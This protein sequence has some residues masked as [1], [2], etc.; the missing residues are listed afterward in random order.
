V[1]FPSNSFLFISFILTDRRDQNK[2]KGKKYCYVLVFYFL[3]WE[4]CRVISESWSWLNGYDDGAY[5]N[6]NLCISVTHNHKRGIYG[7]LLLFLSSF[8]FL[9]KKKKKKAHRVKL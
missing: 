3:V 8:S 7:F 1:L 9:K 6:I 4:I 2:Y 5:T